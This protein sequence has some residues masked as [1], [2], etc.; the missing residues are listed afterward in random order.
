VSI[1]A[2]PGSEAIFFTLQAYDGTGAYLNSQQFTAYA[3]VSYLTDQAGHIYPIALFGSTFWML[4]NYQL[5]VAGSY[6]YGDN[7][8]NEATFGRLYAS[9][10]L[11]QVP[12]G[13]QLPTTADWNALFGLFGTP[14]QAYAALI[15]GG[16]SGF[17]AQLGGQRVIQPNGTGIY[18]QQYVYG[19]YWASGG[20]AA[21]FSSVSGSVA[22]GTPVA[23]PANGL[24]VRFIKHA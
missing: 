8:A 24:S 1:P 16:R 7:P 13:W 23:N 15:P 18:Q 4:A 19:Y 17:N 21:Q 3:Q 14:T 12:A 6:D 5:N 2:P 11:T 9:T 20:V 10:A 22:A